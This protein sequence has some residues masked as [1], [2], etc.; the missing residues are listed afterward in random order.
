MSKPDHFGRRDFLRGLAGL[1]CM[2]MASS[3]YVGNAASY[4]ADLS[5]A[6]TLSFPV[7]GAYQPVVSSLW[8][9]RGEDDPP[10]PLFKK[11]IEA[12]TDFS[13]LS[14][15]DRV[16][17]KLALNSGNA[18]PAA[19]DP[20]SLRCL[21]RVLRE[22]GAGEIWAGDQ[23]SVQ[24]VLWQ[25]TTQRGSSRQLCDSAGLLPVM[26][27]TGA[28]PCFFEERGYDA[29]T[30]SFPTGL[31]HWDR[32]LWITTTVDEVDHIIYLARVSSHVL[33]DI[34]SGMKL[35]VGFL[36][37]DSRHA[38]HQGG[39]DFYA[40]YEEISQVPAISRRLRL[41]VSSGRSVISTLGPDDGHVSVPEHGLVFASEDL[42]AH[43]LLSYAWLKWNR[44]HETGP[45]SRATTGQVTRCRSGLNKAYVWW[46][47]RS[48]D[49]K[50]TPS[51]PFW[52]A[53]DVYG[54]PSIVNFIRRKGGRP[55]GIAWEEVNRG[56]DRSVAEYLKGQLRI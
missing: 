16:F 44:C 35:A 7:L 28:M 29:Y 11:M 23:S 13:W 2:K 38:F 31:H 9:P 4:G 10:Y 33:A 19:T 5:A 45:F 43:E 41:V 40:M 8:A 55:D 48:G 46:I 56:P 52:Q 14:R 17:I 39:R 15:G 54:H 53:G 21:V 22:K 47:W 32:P 24:R 26:L 36:R 18:F 42:L 34:T 50:K 49:E 37:E 30:P 12:A 3:C 6:Q 20:W 51:L 27:D 25:R 1:A